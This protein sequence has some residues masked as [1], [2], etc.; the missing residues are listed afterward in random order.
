VGGRVHRRG[1]GWDSPRLEALA[2]QRGRGRGPLGSARGH[3]SRG[4]VRGP[5]SSEF[6]GAFDARLLDPIIASPTRSLVPSSHEVRTRPRSR[7]RRRRGPRGR[8]EAGGR[9]AQDLP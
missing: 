4:R 2:R 5:V 8:G 6:A 3:K 9:A 1:A 7:P